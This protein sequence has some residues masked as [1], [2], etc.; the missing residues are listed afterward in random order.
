M[1]KVQITALAIILLY[2]LATVIIGLV[3]S[4]SQEKK[5]N[6]DFLMASKSLGPV[7]LAGTLFAANTGE[8]AQQ[9]LLRTFLLM[10]YQQHGM[11]LQEELVLF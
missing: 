9:E 7:V 2:M 3:A 10:D 6:D 11:S 1:S 4:K 8:L 5:S